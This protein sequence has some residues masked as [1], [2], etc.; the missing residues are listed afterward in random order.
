[1][2]SLSTPT[3]LAGTYPATGNWI[4]ED[5]NL[6]AMVMAESIIPVKAKPGKSVLVGDDD[7]ANKSR[8]H[9]FR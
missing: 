6:T 1:M 4:I 5:S 3:C 7:L 8:F 9:V 2:S